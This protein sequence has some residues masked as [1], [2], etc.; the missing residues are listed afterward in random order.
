MNAAYVHLLLNHIPLIAL[1][2]AL[3]FLIHSL[4]TKNVLSRRFALLILGI[5]A[6]TVVPVYFSG[7]GAE[8]LIENLADVSKSVIH[9]HEEAAEVSLVLTL[10]AGAFAFGTLVLERVWRRASIGEELLDQRMFR[11]GMVLSLLVMVAT[12]S[13]GVAAHLGGEIRHPEVRPGFV[14]QVEDY[15]A[16]RQGERRHDDD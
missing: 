4:R 14:G 11:L 9:E 1:P 3:L 5:A 8:E 7:E 2:T 16:P 6:I 10:V 15:A 12:G 13:L